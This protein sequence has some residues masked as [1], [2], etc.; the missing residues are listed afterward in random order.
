M[1]VEDGLGDADGVGEG[2][3][4]GATKAAF[5]EELDGGRHYGGAAIFGRHTLHGEGLLLS[6]R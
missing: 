3:G 2:A 4:G 6:A 5:G 1:L